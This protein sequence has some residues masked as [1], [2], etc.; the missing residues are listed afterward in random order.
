LLA[1]VHDTADYR[2]LEEAVFGNVYFE[3]AIRSGF[4]RLESVA[5]L[6]V[7]DIGC[8]TGNFSVY[9]A[10]HGARV[11]GFDIDEASLRRA[12]LLAERWGV[13]DRCVFLCCR[14]EEIAVAAGAADLIFSR[15]TLQYVD[16]QSLFQECMRVLKRGGSILL[17]EN[18]PYNPLI[19][20]YRLC[21]RWKA[22]T[23]GEVAYLRSIRSYLTHGE[24]RRWQEPFAQAEHEDYHLAAAATLAIR[25]KYRHSPLVLALD[26]AVQAFDRIVFTVLPFMR[27]FAWLVAVVGQGKKEVAA[28]AAR[29]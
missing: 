23:P 27:H 15:S 4:E 14:S 8:G 19:N 29:P 20:L 2:A 21:R 24:I 12:V 16:R 28:H 3:R 1:T 25:H 17:L 11:I 7:V 10:L 5:G 13:Q 6:T 26:R 18:L 22:R 9:F